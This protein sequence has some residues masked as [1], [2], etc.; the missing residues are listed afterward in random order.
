M[1]RAIVYVKTDSEYEAHAARCLEH[2]QQRGYEFQG[3]IRDDWEA[4]QKMLGDGQTSVIIVASETQLDP[5]RKPRIEVVANQP[6]ATKWE[7]RTRLIRR[8]AGG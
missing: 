5:D 6:P 7:E 2:C 8:N 4:A 3:L 1:T